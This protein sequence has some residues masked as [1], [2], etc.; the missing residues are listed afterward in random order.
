[1]APKS[2]DTAPRSLNTDLVNSA[3]MPPP[4]IRKKTVTAR[5]TLVS[6]NIAGTSGLTKQEEPIDRVKANIKIAGRSP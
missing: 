4:K 6:Y 5:S 3:V 1:M 2:L